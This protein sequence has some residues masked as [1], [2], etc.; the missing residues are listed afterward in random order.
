MR[1][2]L[3]PAVLACALIG[4]ARAQQF[5]PKTYDWVRA[6]DEILELDP[7]DY[8]TG[9]VYRP[10]PDGGNM[11]V[12]IEAKQPV[13]LAMTWTEDWTA[14]QQHPETWGSLE[15]R[16]MR[17]HVTSTTYECHLPPG[18]SMVLVIHDERT[19]DRAILQG[20]G[21]ILGKNGARE[22]MSPNDVQLTYHSWSCV[23]N[24]VQPEF[25]WVRLVKEKYELSLVPKLY[26]ILIP[27][28]DGQK[29]WMKIKAPMP[30]TL[31]VMPSA[32]ADKV[33]DNPDEFG[34][35]VAQTSCKQRGVESMEFDCRFNFADGPQSLLIVPNGP[36]KS[37]KKAEIEVQALQCMANCDLLTPNGMKP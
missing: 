18:R 20:I 10:G 37:H 6:S 11:H 7:A 23:A 13:T 8:H 29:L 3:I 35:A 26:S 9:R 19:P 5:P 22:L 33:Y 32:M 34:S 14:A 24:C 25:N 16:C 12:I 1:T 17:E 2:W 28:H 30:M 21:V 31:A 36:L 27:E 15:Y 4:C